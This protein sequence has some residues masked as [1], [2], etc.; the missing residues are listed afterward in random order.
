MA[1][2]STSAAGTAGP[3]VRYSDR[4]PGNAL[5][6]TAV[7]VA[8]AFPGL[9]PGSAVPDRCAGQDAAGHELRAELAL[10]RGMW[11]SAAGSY[12]CAARLSGDATTAERATRVAFEHHQLNAAVEAAGRW[13]ELE[14]GREEAH[15]YL[16]VGLL[17]LYRDQEAVPHFARVLE[18]AYEDRAQGYMALLGTLTDEPNDTGAARLI[19]VLAEGDAGLAEAQY[20]RSVLWQRADHGERALEAAREALQLRPGWRMAELAEVRA[21]LTL[22]RMDEGLARAGELATDGDPLTRLTRAWLL[23]GAARDE[24]AAAVFEDLRRSQSAVPQALEGLGAIAY[25]RR[26]YD[27]AREY[28]GEMLKIVRDD[29]T[30][31]AY[32]GLIADEKDQPAAALRYLERVEAGARAV[33]SQL[34]AYELGAA[35]GAPERAAQVLDDF[36]SRSPASARDVV[37]GRANQ[38]VRGQRGEEALALFDRALEFY[39]DDDDLRLAKAFSL[40]QLDEIP[41][42]VKVMREVLERR[43]E[44]PTALNSLGYTLVDR[45]RRKEEGYELVQRALEA[46]PDSYAIMDSV[47]WALFRL[48]RRQEALDHLGRAWERSRDPEVAAHLGEVLWAEGRVDEAREIWARGLEKGPDNRTLKRTIERH[49]G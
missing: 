12:A 34:K 35:L 9:A 47:G 44:D 26:D 4:M 37:V 17:R 46:K 38:L 25:S 24:E 33:A 20:A 7:L 39:P 1:G 6:R 15:R 28:F 23:V 21:L 42:A 10:A 45:T 36:L 41:A 22:G 11:P 49:P 8:L 2:G 5:R 16:A 40:E 3:A 29:D 43:P 31:L 18:Q 19:E 14:P 27:A 30:A 13:T 32:L 48:G